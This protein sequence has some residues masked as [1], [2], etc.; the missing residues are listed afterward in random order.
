MNR[1]TVSLI[2]CASLLLGVPSIAEEKL[3][4]E[5][6]R[7][8]RNEKLER[9]KVRDLTQKRLN[10]AVELLEY[11]Q[12]AEARKKLEQSRMRRL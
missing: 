3:D 10:I 11:E 7:A 9:Y 12:Y 4:L 8:E 1:W 5:A 6:L 2:T